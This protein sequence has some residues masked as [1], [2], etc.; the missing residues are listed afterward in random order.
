[1]NTSGRGAAFDPWIANKLR[2][3][4]SRGKRTGLK[5][6][7]SFRVNHGVKKAQ[8]LADFN[9]NE[10][11]VC[12]G[13]I[14]EYYLK[15]YLKEVSKSNL[16]KVYPNDRDKYDFRTDC[17]ALLEIKSHRDPTHKLS[18]T[19]ESCLA[20]IPRANKQIDYMIKSGQPFMFMALLYACPPMSLI[21]EFS[22][23][24]YHSVQMIMGVGSD[25]VFIDL[26]GDDFIRL[27]TPDKSST[28]Y[29]KTI[30]QY[31]DSMSQTEDQSFGHITNVGPND[32]LIHDRNTLLEDL[33][34]INVR[35]RT[36]TQACIG[37][38]IDKNNPDHEV[39][40][41]LDMKPLLVALLLIQSG[42]TEAEADNEVFTGFPS[43]PKRWRGK[44]ARLA[45]RSPEI[46]QI[47]SIIKLICKSMDVDFYG[48][49]SEW[50]SSFE[51]DPIWFLFGYQEVKQ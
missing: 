29:N 50:A 20:S 13:F 5:F 39:I 18:L 45:N 22:I 33:Q 34:A 1:M 10:T 35:E 46:N 26:R 23:F 21:Q 2:S 37:Y 36:T 4:I 28:L 30:S 17:G 42:L 44:P 9:K 48:F 19:C 12:I 15:T 8:H 40:N 3:A 7:N 31:I 16:L 43:C 32:T 24:K 11:G 49:M 27:F 14:L 38:M 51:V 25:N 6:V 41:W 47:F